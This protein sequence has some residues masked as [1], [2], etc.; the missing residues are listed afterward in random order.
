MV[1]LL[2]YYHSIIMMLVLYYILFSYINS[3]RRTVPGKSHYWKANSMIALEETGIRSRM[4]PMKIC[5][6]SDSMIKKVG[7]AVC[8]ALIYG[9]YG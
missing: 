5:Q 3:A 2:Q 9:L 8:R 7:R 4:K 1:I 6:Q